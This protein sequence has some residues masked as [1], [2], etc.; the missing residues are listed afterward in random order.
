ME[1][2]WSVE[3]EVSAWAKDVSVPS[4]FCCSDV[5]SLC[6]TLLSVPVGLI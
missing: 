1:S 3:L 5:F 4:A 2:I 6:P